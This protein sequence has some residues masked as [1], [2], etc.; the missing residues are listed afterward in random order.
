M[1]Q[2][3][4][5][6]NESKIHDHRKFT[7]SSP[8]EHTIW[9]SLPDALIE[10]LSD[11]FDVHTPFELIYCTYSLHGQLRLGIGLYKD[12]IHCFVKLCHS[13]K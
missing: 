5:T 9:I 8:H 13:L 6:K 1:N 7:Y 2:S 10:F 12:A 3:C 4:R 11:F